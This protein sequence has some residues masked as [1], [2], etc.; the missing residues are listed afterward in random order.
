M[1][2]DR[3]GFDYDE[4][5]FGHAFGEDPYDR[6]EDDSTRAIERARELLGYRPRIGARS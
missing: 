1:P 2:I 3:D 5:L 6:D 4:S